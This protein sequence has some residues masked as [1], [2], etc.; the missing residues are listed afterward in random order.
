MQQFDGW[1]DCS[2]R[3]Y[4][5]TR[6]E[7]WFDAIRKYICYVYHLLDLPS[8]EVRLARMKKRKSPCVDVCQ[9][10]GPNGW[11]IGC[12]RSREE[13]ARWK[14]MKPFEVNKIENEIKQRMAKMT[15]T[16]PSFL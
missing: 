11:C 6:F 15:Q 3:V 9:F 4:S 5:N 2:Y 16:P 12:G 7:Q 14:K 8:Y 1:L 13:C 10:S